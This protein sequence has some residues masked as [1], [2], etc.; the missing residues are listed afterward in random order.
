MQTHPEHPDG[1]RGALVLPNLI[2]IHVQTLS[3]QVGELHEYF[4][5]PPARP[6][7]SHLDSALWIIYSIKQNMFIN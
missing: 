6:S 5:P 4:S 1:C 2:T 3:E 7:N